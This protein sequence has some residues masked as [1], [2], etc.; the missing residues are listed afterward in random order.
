MIAFFIVRWNQKPETKTLEFGTWN[1][2]PETRNLKPGT[3]NSQ[4]SIEN[5]QCLAIIGILVLHKRIGRGAFG[6]R[7]IN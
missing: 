7:T 5:L 6:G 1:Q 2:E 3:R 4:N